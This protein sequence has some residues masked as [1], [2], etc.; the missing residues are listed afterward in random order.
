MVR[1]PGSSEDAGFHRDSQ[2]DTDVHVKKEHKTE[3]GPS[4]DGEN[5]E[6]KVPEQTKNKIAQS[7]QTK[8]RMKAPGNTKSI[9]PE[10]SGLASWTDA[11]A[12][13]AYHQRKLNAFLES[14]P[15]A[16][17]L[18]IRQLGQLTGPV[19]TL[20][21]C[22]P[23]TTTLE[24]MHKR[25]SILV[26]TTPATEHPPLVTPTHMQSKDSQMTLQDITVGP[27]MYG[28]SGHPEANQGPSQH[29]MPSGQREAAPWSPGSSSTG[30]VTRMPLGPTE[31]ALLQARARSAEQEP[32]GLETATRGKNENHSDFQP[33]EN[34]HEKKLEFAL[35]RDEYAGGEDLPTR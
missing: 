27:H 10:K 14:D 11:D 32:S 23:I 28:A 34:H 24:H 17:T 26:G 2:D 19:S 8:F 31:A 22:T 35:P 21:G 30:S 13:R 3:E 1:V 12:T 33:M 18:E 7:K 16:K 4:A 15:V 9:V 5:R 20:H 29:L 6:V 25:L